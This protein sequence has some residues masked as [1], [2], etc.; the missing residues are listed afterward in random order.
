M[1]SGITA[2]Y[3]LASKAKRV[4]DP[5]LDRNLSQK[6]PAKITTVSQMLRANVPLSFLIAGI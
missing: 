1:I 6:L 5:V 4:S 3:F 2:S